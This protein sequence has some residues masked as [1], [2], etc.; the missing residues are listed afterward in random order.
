MPALVVDASALAAICFSEQEGQFAAKLVMDADLFSTPLLD[1]ELANV[2]WKK[3]R[4]SV[5]DRSTVERALAIRSSFVITVQ[6]VDLHGVID[7]ALQTGLTAYDASYLWRARQL[8][9]ELVTF[10]RRLARAAATSA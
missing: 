9:A 2:A 5:A 10:D 7:L 6:P 4:Q 3:L 8:G 1:L